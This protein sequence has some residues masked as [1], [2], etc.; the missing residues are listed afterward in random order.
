V[1]ALRKGNRHRILFGE[2]EVLTWIERELAGQPQVV[3]GIVRAANHKTFRE[4]P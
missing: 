1:H 2:V 3:P 4:I